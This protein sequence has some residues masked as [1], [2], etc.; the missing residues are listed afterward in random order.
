MFE[1]NF[2]RHV[3]GRAAQGARGGVQAPRG[4]VLRREGEFP[5]DSKVQDF[6][7]AGRRQHDV[8]ALQVAVDNLLFMRSAERLSLAAS[9]GATSPVAAVPF[10]AR[11]ENGATVFPVMS[12]EWLGSW[13]AV[14]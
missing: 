6:H 5:S 10:F 9:A 8:L 12:L 14:S 1:Q 13:A 4:G 3:G 11:I 2:R 7:L